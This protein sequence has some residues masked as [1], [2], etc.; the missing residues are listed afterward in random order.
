MSLIGLMLRIFPTERMEPNATRRIRTRTASQEVATTIVKKCKAEHWKLR[1][2]S[3]PPPP[4]RA[5]KVKTTVVLR[6]S[7]ALLSC[8]AMTIIIKSFISKFDDSMFPMISP[9]KQQQQQQHRTMLMAKESPSYIHQISKQQQPRVSTATIAQSSS[10]DQRYRWKP[11]NDSDKN[12]VGNAIFYNIYIPRENP[13]TAMSTVKEQ[14]RQIQKSSER[15]NTTTTAMLYYTLIGPS[16]IREIMHH[17]YNISFDASLIGNNHH[18]LKH[19]EEGGEDLTLDFL[20]EY[21]LERPNATVAYIHDK[22]SL[23]AHW[24]GVRRRR[25]HATAAALSEQC[26]GIGSD[27]GSDN[28]HIM[29][30]TCAASIGFQPHHYVPANMWAAKCSYLRQLVRPSTLSSKLLSVYRQIKDMS[31]TSDF[32]HCLASPLVLA[33]FDDQSK[34]KKHISSSLGV[35]RE[36]N[37]HW[38]T[39]HPDWQPCS[40]YPTSYIQYPQHRQPPIQLKQEPAEPIPTPSEK[41]KHE[42]THHPIF[43]TEGYLYKYQ[44]LY[45]QSPSNTGWFWWYYQNLNGHDRCKSTNNIGQL[46]QDQLFRP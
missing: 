22:G 32:Y 8:I 38:L 28:N 45:N 23:H 39:L 10:N 12:D 15:S 29:C 21:C 24:N 27:N 11:L 16:N 7:R 41:D 9:N 37:A 1:G 36:A 40:V 3:P 6:I 18:L 34:N 46:D 31:N 4:R 43:Q 35:F 25:F 20:W 14:L 26:F 5:C 30:N 17:H 2:I 19:V 33:L 13:M 44:F 42:T